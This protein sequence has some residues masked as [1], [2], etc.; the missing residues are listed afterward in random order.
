MARL[1]VVTAPTHITHEGAPAK[2][3]SPEQELRRSV[4]ACMLWEDTFYEGG[5]SVAERIASLVPMV[6]PAKVADLAIEARE[7]MKLRHM[8]L[9]LVR[10]LARLRYPVAPLLERVIQRPDEMAEFLAIYWKDGRQPLANQVK[11]GLARAFRKFDAHRL[12]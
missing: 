6:S 12:A 9:L 1:N 7:R 5:E 8:P 2:R 4:L 3:I 10:E 11:R